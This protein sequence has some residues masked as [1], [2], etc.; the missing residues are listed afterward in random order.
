MVSQAR[1]WSPADS[2]SASLKKTP[3][4]PAARVKIG[5]SVYVYN[6]PA[7]QR[8]KVA[9]VRMNVPEIRFVVGCPPVTFDLRKGGMG[10]V[11][12]QAIYVFCVAKGGVS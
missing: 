4:G 11:S 3:P 5:E 2:V 8:R 9:L 12:L 10:C 6:S 1:K 7:A